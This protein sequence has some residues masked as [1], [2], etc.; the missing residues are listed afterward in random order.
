MG[1][2]RDKDLIPGLGRSPGGENGNPLQYSGLENL[3][4]GPGGLQYTGSQIVEH[5]LSYIA[6][7]LARMNQHKI[8][9]KKKVKSP[10]QKN[11]PS[12]NQNLFLEGVVG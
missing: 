9:K 2:L 8:K 1:D 5:G 3:I 6:C 10:K 11:N 4:E 12:G 7:M